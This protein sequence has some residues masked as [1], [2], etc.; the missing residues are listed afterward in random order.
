MT[1]KAEF[2]DAR[3]KVYEFGDGEPFIGTLENGPATNTILNATTSFLMTLQR[4]TTMDDAER[5]VDQLNRLVRKISIQP[6]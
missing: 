1:L 2:A 5:L 3:F 4:G 6:Q